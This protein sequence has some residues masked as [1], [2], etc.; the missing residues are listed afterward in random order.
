MSL[1]LRIFKGIENKGNRYYGKFDERIREWVG[2]VNGNEFIEKYEDIC[3]NEENRSDFYRYVWIKLGLGL[4]CSKSD[5]RYIKSLILNI[6]NG[7]NEFFKNRRFGNKDYSFEEFVNRI[8]GN[9]IDCINKL[10]DL[11]IEWKDEK[12]YYGFEKY[13]NMSKILSKME[14][15]IMNERMSELK[16]NN[17]KYISLF[18]GV[19]VKRS[20]KNKVLNIMNRKYESDLDMIIRFK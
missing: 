15:I 20:E 1:L 16:R 7:K 2:D 9:G 5:R 8:F 10:K 11:D 14:V 12:S 3:F 18:D 19:L 17:I 4:S 13:K 6:I